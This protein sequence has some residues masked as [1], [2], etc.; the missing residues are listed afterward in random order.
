[1]TERENGMNEWERNIILLIRPLFF[2]GT[3][4]NY[5]MLFNILIVLILYIDRDLN[6]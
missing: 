5:L 2:N 6:Y 3:I 1:M 4:F